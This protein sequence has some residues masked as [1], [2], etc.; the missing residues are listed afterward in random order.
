MVSDL[1]TLDQAIEEALSLFQH[2]FPLWR[3]HRDADWPLRPEVFRSSPYGR[4]Y[5]ELTLLRCFMDQA[6]SRHTRC[7]PGDDRLG[8]LMLA[9]HFG[10]PTRLLDWS[11]SPL[12]ALYFAAQ[13]DDVH[14]SD[15]CLWAL[16]PSF[17]NHQMMGF[18]TTPRM[19]VSDEPKVL[20]LAN[21]AF[22]I[23]PM[24]AAAH[25]ASARGLAL[26][27]SAREIDARMFTQQGAFTIHGDH[28]DLADTA[29]LI[30]QPWKRVFRIPS[31]SKAGLRE[32]MHRLS[33]NKSTLFPD[34]GALA[35]ELKSRPY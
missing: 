15:G 11:W 30:S 33:I 2:K 3:G 28:A 29:E 1:S 21:A 18:P 34:L 5:E 14:D 27:I 16:A 19:M 31:G 23:S 7:P 24:A 25:M 6:E 9:R 12:V 22:E 35:E 10:L 13:P 4:T 17:M 32:L 26:A 8:W 20:E